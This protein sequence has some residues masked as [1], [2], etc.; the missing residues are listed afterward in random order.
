MTR[1]GHMRRAREAA[2][3]TL[4]E[5]AERSGVAFSHIGALERDARCG[6]IV[7]VELLADA[8]G[9]SIDEYTGHETKKD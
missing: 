9:L 1:G 2:G 8:L 6:N 4:R 5:L 3:L 7:T